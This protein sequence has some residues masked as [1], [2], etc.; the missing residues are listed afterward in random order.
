M[1]VRDHI[2]Y[3][4]NKSWLT[5]INFVVKFLFVMSCAYWLTWDIVNERWLY[6]IVSVFF[7]TFFLAGIIK[8][9][10]TN[11]EEAN[12]HFGMEM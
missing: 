12:N 11:D 4:N 6:A 2:M 8:M 10:V 7:I 1:K 3:K 5:T 9:S